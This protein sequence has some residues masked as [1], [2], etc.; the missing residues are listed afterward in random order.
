VSG[1]WWK[2]GKVAEC[3]RNRIWGSE[4]LK[5]LVRELEEAEAGLSV[6]DG[7]DH[8]VGHD[9]RLGKCLLSLFFVNSCCSYALL[10]C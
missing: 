4:E 2:K 7:K 9:G 5:K 3:L 1:C 10:Q 8:R 6:G